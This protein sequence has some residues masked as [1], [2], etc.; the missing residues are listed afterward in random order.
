MKRRGRE[1]ELSTVY[2]YNKATGGPSLRPLNL[3]SFLPF[4]WTRSSLAPL[5]GP[6]KTVITLDDVVAGVNGPTSSQGWVGCS[7]GCVCELW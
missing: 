7:L 1:T 2:S 5:S 6:H 3:W 4:L